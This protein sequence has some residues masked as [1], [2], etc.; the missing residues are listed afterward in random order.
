MRYSS[1]EKKECHI[2]ASLAHIDS[3]IKCLY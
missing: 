3:H 2:S 1:T